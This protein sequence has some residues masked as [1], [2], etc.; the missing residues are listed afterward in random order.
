[1]R[2]L[3][4]TLVLLVSI[5]ASIEAQVNRPSS[6][7][8]PGGFVRDRR[9]A[10]ALAAVER[11]SKAGS[12]SDFTSATQWLLDQPRDSIVFSAEGQARSVRR[13]VERILSTGSKERLADYRRLMSPTAS[14]ELTAARRDES[15][16]RL[17]GIV[18][19][20]FY[21]EAGGQAATDLLIRALDSG[22]DEI[23]AALAIRLSEE[24]AH[25]VLLTPGIRN[26]ID[27]TLRR[28]ERKAL[29]DSDL[30][31]GDQ[32]ETAILEPLRSPEV[33]SRHSSAVMAQPQWTL[34]LD[35]TERYGSIESRWKSWQAQQREGDQSTAIAS[36]PIVAQGQVI[37]RD[38]DRLRA[39]D[40]RTGRVTWEQKTNLG[41]DALLSGAI[42][43]LRD[44]ETGTPQRVSL[45][46]NMLA[47]N[48]AY[49]SLTTDGRQVYLVDGVRTALETL[50]SGASLRDL[51]IELR[52]DALKND[53]IAVNA[54]P[55]FRGDNRQV[56]SLRERLQDG[57]SPLRD[58]TF[59]GP[60]LAF[61]G[62]LLA[63]TE[64][65]REIYAV[66]LDP[67]TGHERW[68]QPIAEPDSAVLDDQL[69]FYRSCTPLV[70][71][72]LVFCPT[73]LGSLVALD[74]TSGAF[75]WVHAH[76]DP[77][78][79]VPRNGAYRQPPLLAQNRNA[80]FNLRPWVMGPYVFY[81]AG[82]SDSLFCLDI[83]SGNVKWAVSQPDGE[84]IAHVTDQAVVVVGRTAVH[85][86]STESSA[87]RWSVRLPAVPSGLSVARLGELLVP[88]S[89][90]HLW[91]IALSDGEVLSNGAATERHPTGHLAVTRDGVVALGTSGL[92]AYRFTESVRQDLV[93]SRLP[94]GFSSQQQFQLA[95]VSLAEGRLTEAVDQLESLRKGDVAA[96]N[97]RTHPLLR[98][99]YFSLLIS[100]S[101]QQRLWLERLEPL[102]RH[103]E[104]HARWLVA[105]GD[106]FV[107]RGDLAGLAATMH[108]LAGRPGAALYPMSTDAALASTGI[109]WMRRVWQRLP[110]APSRDQLT[111]AL[112]DETQN[113]ADDGVRARA[114]ET[115]FS[116]GPVGQ[117]VRPRLA[118]AALARGQTH[119]A[120]IWL[121]RNAES[122]DREVAAAAVRQLAELYAAVDMP[123][124]AALQWNRLTTEF[125]EVNCGEGLI[126]RSFV[127]QQSQ[128]SEVAA[129]FRRQNPVAWPIR[130]VLV[131]AERR[132]PAATEINERGGI[133]LRDNGFQSDRFPRWGLLPREDSDFEWRQRI[134][135]AESILM[136][137]DRL[138]QQSRFQM[139][140]SS[141]SLAPQQ[142][143][144]RSVFENA[145]AVGLPA[146]MRMVS[147]LQ[148][149]TDGEAWT[150]SLPEWD[151]RSAMPNPGPATLRMQLYQIFSSRPSLV[152]VDPADGAVL[153]RR[154]DL[155]PNSGLS[156]RNLGLFADDDVVGVLG[157]DRVSYLLLNAATGD[158]IRTGKLEADRTTPRYA[159]GTRIIWVVGG[160]DGKRVRI[161]DAV[162]DRVIFEETIREFFS[163]PNPDRE[164]VWLNTSDEVC[165]FDVKRNQ[166]V[167]RCPLDAT[168][169]GKI[170]NLRV[171]RQAGRYFVNLGRPQP[172]APT[173]HYHTPLSDHAL[174]LA[175]V[176][177]ELLAIDPSGTSIAWRRPVPQMGMLQWGRLPVPFLVAVSKIRDKA[178]HNHEW[179][180]VD[181]LDIT[182][183]ERLGVGDHLPRDRWFHA[184][185]DGD[186]GEVRIHG[187]QNTVRIRFDRGLQQIPD[188]DDVL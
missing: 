93:R 2:L 44:G 77:R 47:G 26:R 9:Q 171:F 21:T 17:W 61:P 168:D 35:F 30:F 96:W 135:G 74:V 156:D 70:A 119:A 48:S 91:R 160:T 62:F 72:G 41:M 147:V 10:E 57:A 88:L 125:A 75:A 53:L 113:P 68:I 52:R 98:D 122:A 37:F 100:Q 133:S 159:V 183:G 188:S 27:L 7:A 12:A 64:S 101:E 87:E 139:R 56:W 106:W 138:A 141:V 137:W 165:V 163:S 142:G 172:V 82:Q 117:K 58:H 43:G 124:A 24:P 155:E 66:A 161:W 127:Q 60:P 105:R 103:G 149:V 116:R 132:A 150:Q 136:P 175:Q 89:D 51:P 128:T 65:D 79:P 4:A 22:S 182:T 90:G 157:E 5:P 67:D 130:R 1:M 120:E 177:D 76:V 55:E 54:H 32:T 126:G 179:L 15:T 158:V 115:I 178:D 39:I 33:D 153:W 13:T 184:D 28:I 166:M 42:P 187:V 180:R 16:D 71:R 121:L 123:S 181:L 78:L 29:A 167:V 94:S 6:I 154:N 45:L 114:L 148:P 85:A 112:I 185:Y 186:R 140:F 34:P 8:P 162:E 173:L 152:A 99:A 46:T 97:S 144:G 86:Y 129:A 19:R 81:L 11:L 174:P 151:G 145:L 36:K 146:Q 31:S 102:C 170:S 164:L 14:A 73:Q 18:R 59:L 25:R 92:A 20:Y 38:G 49:F 110:D 108:D 134:D 104:E 107:S 131:D 143:N 69:R 23:A 118:A 176:K 83:A 80:A 50:L 109:G 111:L 84:Y 95:E 63:I 169:A 40:Y 3:V